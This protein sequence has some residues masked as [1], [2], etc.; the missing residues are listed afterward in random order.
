MVSESHQTHVSNPVIT[1]SKTN[2][3]QGENAVINGWVNYNEESTSDVLL[4]ITATDPQGVKIL[5]ENITSDSDGTFSFD[6]PIPENS[7]V[8][9]YT[10][11]ITSQCREVHREICTHQNETITID[12]KEKKS[13][14]DTSSQPQSN[15]IPDWVK[16]IFVWYAEEKVSEDELLE[17]IE[18]LVNQNIIQIKN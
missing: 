6:L 18:F 11:E 5:D 10:I 17:T 7:E 1:T 2:Y 4:K 14:T 9:K 16:N 8:G 3:I 13:V 12:I 15:K